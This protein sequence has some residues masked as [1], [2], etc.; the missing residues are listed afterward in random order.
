[1]KKMISLVLAV[2]MVLTASLS[3]VSCKKG[4]CDLC[5]EEARLKKAEVLGKEC[6]I[7]GECAEN[8]DALGE[9]FD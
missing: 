5:G 4:E 8:L 2:L 3:L 1:M 7:C 9:L 6:H